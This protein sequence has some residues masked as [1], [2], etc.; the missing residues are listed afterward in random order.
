MQ[1]GKCVIMVTYGTAPMNFIFLLN[2]ILQSNF[3]LLT[4]EM[5]IHILYYVHIQN[6]HFITVLLMLSDWLNNSLTMKKMVTLLFLELLYVIFLF[7]KKS[8]IFYLSFLKIGWS[9][10]SIT[11]IKSKTELSDSFEFFKKIYLFNWDIIDI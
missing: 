3:H 7:D 6:F 4:K 2:F 5:N 10:Y 11:I 9:S 8:R 1:S